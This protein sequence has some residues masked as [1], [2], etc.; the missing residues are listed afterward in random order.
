MHNITIFAKINDNS[1]LKKVLKDSEIIERNIFFYHYEKQKS[2]RVK[3]I[4]FY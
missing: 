4:S 1:N 2:M 3:I